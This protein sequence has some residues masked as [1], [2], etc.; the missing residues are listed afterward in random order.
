MKKSILLFLCTVAALA[1]TAQDR[2]YINDFTIAPG[3]TKEVEIMLDNEYTYTAIQA[4]LTLPE[5]LTVEQE[6]GDYIFELTD[7]KNRNHTISSQM[8][9][10]GAIRILIASQNVK[11][12]SGNSG[13]LVVFNIIADDS[14]SGAKTIQIANII[15]GEV[16]GTEHQLPNSS[17]K[18]TQE[19]YVPPAGDND[20]F[21]I[22]DFTIA[23]GETKEVE[24]MLDNEY[25][26]TA[27]QAELTLPEGLTVEQEDGDYIFELTDRK[28]RNHTISSQMLSSGAI[29]ILIASQNVKTIS[30]NSGA[31]VVFNIIADDSFSGPKT[32][33]ISNIIAGEVDG[34][35]HQ[36]PNSSCTVTQEGGTPPTPPSPFSLTTRM[37]KMKPGD[38]LQVVAEGVEDATWTSSDSTVATVDENGLVTALK[39]G[40]T[41]ITVTTTSGETGWCAIFVYNPGDVN[42]DNVVSGS[43]V[44]A[45]YNLLLN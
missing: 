41:A 17:C 13:A 5:G 16:D 8:L 15:A 30:G 35:E 45:L 29:R 1:A 32:I 34:T 23:P 11:T 2:F 22:N 39:A 20:R 25:T 18:V 28:N 9:S 3:E 4:E 21:Y 26:Y 24:I 37:E 12:I 14:F 36:L 19:G 7:R 43:D 42:G 27:I 6:D 38:T 44:T 33:Q 40:M 10:S 31:L